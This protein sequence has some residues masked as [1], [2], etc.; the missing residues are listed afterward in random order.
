[1]IPDVFQ[2]A[3]ASSD[4]T[5]LLG[6]NVTRFWPFDSAPQPGQQGYGIPYATW[7]IV[8]GS[9]ENYINQKPDSDNIAI[10]VDAYAAKVSDVRDVVIAL[11]DAFED[12]GYVVSYIGEERDTPTG[13]YRSGFTVEFW[14]DR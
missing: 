12:Y 4:V 14:V 6:A 5:D 7:Q 3:R 9:P 8:Y 13:L 10:Q 11:R 2:L 1:M